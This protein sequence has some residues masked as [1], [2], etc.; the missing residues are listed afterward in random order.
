VVKYTTWSRDLKC[1]VIFF[2]QSL[3]LLLF[4]NA[5]TAASVCACDLIFGATR[6]YWFSPAKKVYIKSV[7]LRV[8]IMQVYMCLKKNCFFSSSYSTLRHLGI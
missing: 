5:S 2:F 8:Y 1:V 6:G 7:Y 4:I 3:L